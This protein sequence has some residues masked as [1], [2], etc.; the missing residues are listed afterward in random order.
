MDLIRTYLDKESTL[1]YNNK[2]NNSKNPVWELVRGVDNAGNVL[3]SRHIFSIDLTTLRNK[4]NTFGYKQSQV[5]GHTINFYSTIRYRDDLIGSTN[6]DGFQRD[7]NY[8][9]QIFPIT[10]TFTD[11]I[12][13]DFDYIDNTTVSLNTNT[14]NWF[15]KNPTQTWNQNG[16]YT[17]STAPTGLTNNIQSFEQGNEN[18][19]F[20]L[21]SYIN[22]ILFNTTGNTA[23][24]GI[25]YTSPYENFTT[26]VTTGTTTITNYLTS[27]FSLHC[28]AFF[29]P[30]LQT[31]IN[32]YIND[33][34]Y[35]FYLDKNN[36]L[37]L[38]TNQPISSV[39]SVKIYDNN[40]KLYKTYTGITQNNPTT[41]SITNV[42]IPS[43][44]YTD[45]IMF[46]DVW[47]VTLSNGVTKDI[48]NDFTLQ[49]ED[50][51]DGND[52][53]FD[54][55]RF[56]F[57]FYGIKQDEL[58]NQNSGVRKIQVETKRLYGNQI[59]PNYSVSNMKYRLYTI[60]GNNEIEIIPYTLI[61]RT[62]NGNYFY[63][64]ID[65]LVPQ[66][67]YLQVIIENNGL[68]YTSNKNIKFYIKS[69]V[70]Y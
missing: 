8:Q 42:N 17:G 57:S 1:I 33:D 52:N 43:S 39:N 46:T 16:V 22:N 36:T 49:T 5:T 58:I 66:V 29:E 7:S 61:S 41:F 6:I 24:F 11:G 70:Q 37:C 56:S 47:N 30:Y 32:T 26:G 62:T 59:T 44:G 34:R 25:S 21:T 51:T 48:T 64:D 31:N 19:S 14:P 18:I 38:Y 60:Q 45:L 69:Q 65:S 50:I 54:N 2:T 28:S 53:S 68:T 9:L 63:I 55:A 10:E 23:S 12:G 15:Y 3:Y 27:F 67:Y 35:L 4:I 20:D 13:F 40:D